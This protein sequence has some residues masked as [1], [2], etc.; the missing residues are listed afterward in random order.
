MKNSDLA[1]FHEATLIICGS[2]D[3]EEIFQKC[4]TFLK[5]YLPIESIDC[6]LI[7]QETGEIV[8]IALASDFD[9]NLPLNKSIFLSNSALSELRANI[10]QEA[11]VDTDGRM[12]ISQE[13]AKKIG[14]NQI[15]GIG[16]PLLLKDKRRGVV[17][18][19][20][21]KV[22]IFQEEHIRLLKMLRDPLSIAISNHLRH[23]EVL[24]L[25][26]ALQDYNN[27]LQNELHKTSGTRIIGEKF[28]LRFV[29]EMVR[30]V[31]QLDNHVLILGETGVGKEIIANTLHFTS[32]RRKGPFI[33][34][35]CGA[36]P[37]GLLDSELFGHEKGAFTGATAQ[38]KG[39]F[40]RADK[41]TIFLDE[42]GEL[43]LAA[44]VRLLRVLQ[45]KKIERIGGNC[46]I[47]LD[48]RVIAATHRDLAAMVKSGHFREDLWYRLNVFPVT[49]P[50]LRQRSADIPAFVDYFIE[51]KM[52]ELNLTHRPK[53]A[54]G[55]IERLKAYD[56]PGN[57]R[58]LENLVEREIII[59]KVRHTSEPLQFND[60]N[61]TTPSV[62]KEPIP[63][64]R[65]EQIEFLKLEEIT[66]THI[67][68][69]LESTKG[70]IQGKD[71]AAAILGL[72]PGT[73]RSRMR[74][75]G[76]PFGRKK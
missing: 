5:Q 1:F 45:E 47:P 35:N 33:K 6:N 76:I 20:N 29:M 58:E 23:K 52:R 28:G 59:S 39:R 69:V 48:V 24:K 8:I 7:D 3:I 44:Q 17:G 27:F 30:Q 63:G 57:V 68:H 26:A 74:K 62:I 22:G 75:I 16:L 34:V 51:L 67:Q 21:R 12:S 70:K 38:K 41:G 54:S 40:E 42:V 25:Q 72:N 66:R 10:D 64:M 11:F 37:E 43:P 46:E 60:I 4:F 61:I 18:F 71:G 15:S 53:V 13:L 73:L 49:I 55:A 32:K 50:P 14:V 56:W 9:L 31:A 65:P 2:L 36:I 19:L